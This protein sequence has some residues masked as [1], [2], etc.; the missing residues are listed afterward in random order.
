MPQQTTAAAFKQLKPLQGSNTGA[1]VQEHI[2]YWTKYKDDQE[3]R[4]LAQKSKEA[5]F[6]RK[7]DGKSFENY[8]GLA[9]IEAKGYFKF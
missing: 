2:R 9:G 6:K 5:E 3:A 7:R 1:I 4:G 8:Q